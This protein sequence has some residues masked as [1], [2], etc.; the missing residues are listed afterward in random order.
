MIYVPTDRSSKVNVRMR[1]V[2]AKS[3][4]WTTVSLSSVYATPTVIQFEAYM[5]PEEAQ[6]WTRK[7]RKD[8]LD[9]QEKKGV[10]SA[11]RLQEHKEAETV[12][13]RLYILLTVDSLGS[14]ILTVTESRRSVER[15]K[16]GQVIWKRLTAGEV[17]G[18]GSKRLR[19]GHHEVPKSPEKHLAQKYDIGKKKP[20]EQRN[21]SQVPW[22]W[23][24]FQFLLPKITL[25][26]TTRYAEV[27][28]A[29]HLNTIKMSSFVTP[30]KLAALTG[31][32]SALKEG[33]F[34]ASLGRV[35]VDSYRGAPG[36]YWWSNNA[37]VQSS[38]VAEK[39]RLHKPR[40]ASGLTRTKAER[41]LNSELLVKEW[42]QQRKF[43]RRRYFDLKTEIFTNS[44]VHMDFTIDKVHC[45]HFVEGDV[46]VI[47]KS[48]DTPT[49]YYKDEFTP[50]CSVHVVKS[51]V[52]PSFAPIYDDIQVRLLF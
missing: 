9:I 23:L 47:F 33:A 8:G 21:W 42:M 19:S 35:D 10:G 48:S 24:K 27:I 6:L 28:L 4:P 36:A 50:F 2:N 17:R 40:D 15:L 49:S 45:D 29:L 32:V 31:G 51:L 38:G 13:R 44:E 30:S 14:R 39:S 26:W 1:V 20:A 37:E 3:S 46:P 43:Q 5:Q 18:E 16:A 22:L 52:D 41:D 34:L 25:T 11:R 12:T 7:S